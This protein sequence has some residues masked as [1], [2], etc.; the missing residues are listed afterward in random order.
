[1]GLSEP[2]ILNDIVGR[3]RRGEIDV[4]GTGQLFDAALTLLGRPWSVG[5]AVII[6]PSNIL[7]PLAA[8][9]LALRPQAKAIIL[10]APLETFLVSVA[11]KGMHCRLWARELLEGLIQEGVADLGFTPT[12]IFRQTDLQCA[13]VGWL[14]QHRLFVE[15]FNRYGASRV[16]SLS[17]E[18][19]L[20]DPVATLT[21]A[22]SH[23]ELAIDRLV[24]SQVAAGPVFSRHSKS[25]ERFDRKRRSLAYEEVRLAHSDEIAM[26]VEWARAV[27]VSAGLSFDLAE[28]L[29]RCPSSGGSHP[30]SAEANR[31]R[32]KS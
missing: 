26:V 20:A 1:M 28:E 6:K 32:V 25:G 13:A 29:A 31:T 16:R 8:G 4:H 9:L 12:D 17:S 5:E 27:A 30:L 21:S 24:A 19:L 3:R 11:R 7:N 23:F 2:V 10:F 15:L 14:V 22:G 18:Q